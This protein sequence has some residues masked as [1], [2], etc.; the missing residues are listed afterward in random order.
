MQ[1]WHN[2]NNQS[3]TLLF[4]SP[5]HLSPMPSQEKQT[6]SNFPCLFNQTGNHEKQ[7]TTQTCN[8]QISCGYALRKGDSALLHNK[9]KIIHA[10]NS[11]D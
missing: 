9:K 10:L 11:F 1:T 7:Y 2:F 3:Q 8:I 6:I 4:H 5:N